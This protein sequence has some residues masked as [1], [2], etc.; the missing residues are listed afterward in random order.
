ML[1]A[2]LV[3]ALGGTLAVAPTATAGP[4]DPV[5]F[6]DTTLADA[7]NAALGQSPGDTITEAQ[8][9]AVAVL[10]AAGLGITDLTGIEYLTGATRLELGVN[11]ISDLRP[12]QV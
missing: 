7:V 6:A 10:D 12:C 8:A 9:A 2:T 4:S 1:V 3:L 5:T 11:W